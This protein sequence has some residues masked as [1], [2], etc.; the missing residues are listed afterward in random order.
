[1]RREMRGSGKARWRRD[2][3]G[4]ACRYPARQQLITLGPVLS[5]ESGCSDL[6]GA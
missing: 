1:M 3:S 5:V 4:P 6:E 2:V